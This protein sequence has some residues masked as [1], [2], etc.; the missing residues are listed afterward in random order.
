M[1]L[2]LSALSGKETLLAH[3]EVETFETS[4]SEALYRVGLANVTLCLVSRRFCGNKAVEHRQPY[5]ALRFLFHPIE[6]VECLNLKK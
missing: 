3:I 1:I 2:V 4:V 6:E 5:H